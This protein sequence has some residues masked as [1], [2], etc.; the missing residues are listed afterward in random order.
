M[1]VRCNNHFYVKIWNHPSGTTIE[2]IV[3]S[4]TRSLCQQETK[5]APNKKALE[6]HFG[7]FT[8]NVH[9]QMYQKK[10]C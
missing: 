2:K 5:L 4:G 6:A 9:Q 1:D 8:G 10:D 7:S 3:V